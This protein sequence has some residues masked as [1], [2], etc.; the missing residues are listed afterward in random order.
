[1][2][3]GEREL[4][5]PALVVLLAA[6]LILLGGQPGWAG[7]TL[8]SLCLLLPL[9]AA[10]VVGRRGPQR[11]LERLRLGLLYA[12]ALGVYLSIEWIVPA[13]GRLPIDASLLAID[14]ALFGQ[15]PALSY[16]PGRAAV[17]LLSLCY[18]GYHG[19]LHGALL[20]AGLDEE[21]ARRLGLTLFRTF[22]LGFAGYLLFPARGPASLGLFDRP[23]SSGSISR[24]L[25]LLVDHGS[26]VYDAFPSMHVAITL[27][28]LAHDARCHRWRF[29]ALLLPT[30]GLLF[31]TVAL[32]YH[33]A[34][35][36][37]AGVAL[38]AIV[39]AL[40]WR[41]TAAEQLSWVR[42]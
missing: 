11:Y 5:L 9:V 4:I 24:L 22:A 1:M 25:D 41:T 14:E 32:R 33:Y 35:D 31:S 36:V 21:R 20:W 16:T 42:R 38:V 13:S 19:Y 40:S 6:G 15:T 28:L 17:G 8:L 34:V 29:W 30:L 18:M 12:W 2:S 10:W 27:T 26:S 23:L 3:E 39:V 7:N 37:I